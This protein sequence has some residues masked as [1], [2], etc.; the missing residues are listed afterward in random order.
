MK[1]MGLGWCLTIILTKLCFCL[2]VYLLPTWLFTLKWDS[3]GY[4]LL[5]CLHTSYVVNFKFKN[6][7]LLEKPNRINHQGILGFNKLKQP[8]L[9]DLKSILE[10]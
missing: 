1:N 8:E 2:K 9:P 7:R 6:I 10:L 5:A 3:N 4:K